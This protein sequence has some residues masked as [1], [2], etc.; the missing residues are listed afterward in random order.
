MATVSW[1]AAESN[2]SAL[3]TEMNSLANGSICTASS[4]IT[5]SSGL[6]RWMSIY[7]HLASLTPSAGGYCLVYLVP[8]LDGS[9]YADLNTSSLNRIIAT[10]TPSTSGS[11]KELIEV[12]I[13]IPPFDFKLAV[14]NSTGV[15]LAASANTLSY[16]RHNEQVA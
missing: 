10:L 11:V 4:A 12:N 7:L 1:I 5:N 8:T 2:T 14:Q 13:P 15:T 9:I 16:R 3:T 6:Y